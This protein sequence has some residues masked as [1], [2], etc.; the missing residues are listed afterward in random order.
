[1]NEVGVVFAFR[2]LCKMRDTL[3]RLVTKLE[4][5][6]ICIRLDWMYCCQIL[7]LCFGLLIFIV[8]LFVSSEAKPI[9]RRESLGL[10]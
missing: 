8:C 4:L 6:N 7:M 5:E 2:F 10:W 9:S 3:L 1:M